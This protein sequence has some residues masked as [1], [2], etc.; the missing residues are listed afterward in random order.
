MSSAK[1]GPFI[2]WHL[3]FS[4][5]G[6]SPDD[7]EAEKGASV[8]TAEEP[9]GISEKEGRGAFLFWIVVG[10]ILCLLTAIF[11]VS[12]GRRADAS[13][14]DS[15][16]LLWIVILAASVIIILAIVAADFLKAWKKQQKK[17]GKQATKPKK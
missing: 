8:L 9:R 16:S 2:P 17:P 3:L 6:I 1:G 15:G 14:E 10:F 5:T 12:C 11:A 13:Q 7:T 4:R